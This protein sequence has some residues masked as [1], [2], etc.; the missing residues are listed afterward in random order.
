MPKLKRLPG[1]QLV[2]MGNGRALISLDPDYSIAQLELDVRDARE[3]ANSLNDAERALLLSIGSIL[4]EA[5]HSRRVTLKP[6][7]IIVI[8][9][10]RQRRPA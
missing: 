2:P 4:R 8:E 7:T 6:R 10:K 3:Q 5:R 9:R 1:V